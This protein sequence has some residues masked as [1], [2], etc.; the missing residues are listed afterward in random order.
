MSGRAARQYRTG[1]EVPEDRVAF[2]FGPSFKALESMTPAER[3]D[4][5]AE[6]DSSF[7][8]VGLNWVGKCLI[9]NGPLAFDFKTREGATLEH[10]RARGRGGTDDPTN[11]GIVHGRQETRRHPR[12]KL[13]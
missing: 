6:T 5:V 7:R 2:L 12:L 8:R 3:L 9:C 1:P 11:L 10:V 13:P 4:H